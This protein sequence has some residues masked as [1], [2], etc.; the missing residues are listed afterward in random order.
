MLSRTIGSERDRIVIG[1]VCN[2][3]KKK[4]LRHVSALIQGDALKDMETNQAVIQGTPRQQEDAVDERDM[5][6][7]IHG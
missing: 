2:V 4:Y 6:G 3:T 5:I 7:V 1:P